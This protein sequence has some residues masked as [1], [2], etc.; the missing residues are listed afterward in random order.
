[1][2]MVKETYHPNAYLS[3]IRNVRLGL[4]TRTRILIFLEKNSTDARTIAKRTELHYA[5]VGHHLKLL[6]IEGIVERKGGGKPRIWAVTGVG[7]KRL[8]GSS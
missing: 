3:M 8:L 7:Q 5:V 6:A 2:S 4:R 1:M